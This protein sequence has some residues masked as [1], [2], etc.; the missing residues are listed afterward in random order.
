MTKTEIIEN[1]YI[2]LLGNLSEKE[3]KL[4]S[5]S[6]T[7]WTPKLEDD[8]KVLVEHNNKT[9]VCFKFPTARTP[10]WV[11]VSDFGKLIMHKKAYSKS[12][13][14]IEELSNNPYL[15]DIISARYKDRQGD[16]L[17]KDIYPY[18]RNDGNGWRIR[19]DPNDSYG[20]SK[21]DMK[22]VN[23]E[24]LSYMMY[25]KYIEKE[26]FWCLASN[27]DIFIKNPF[28]KGLLTGTFYLHHI[29]VSDGKSLHKSN[30]EP[31]AI[32]SGNLTNKKKI[33]LMKCILLSDNSHKAKHYQTPHSDIRTYEVEQLPYVLRSKK[34][35]NDVI[36]ELEISIDETYEDFIL[37]MVNPLTN[38]EDIV[39][40][41][42]IVQL[43]LVD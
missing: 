24:S 14:I 12:T 3:K 27:I 9:Y 28:K 43:G 37:G 15:F 32:L 20:A 35:F 6:L 23:V 29:L 2:P 21:G 1:H 36:K 5:E 33:E 11:N 7:I 16:L 19:D 34:N 4:V 26:K 22:I 42:L 30:L 39:E 25:G 10:Y 38:N 17:I 40:N 8:L 18:I 31:S 41:N 13:V